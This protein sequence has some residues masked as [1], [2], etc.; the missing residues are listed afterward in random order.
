MKVASKMSFSRSLAWMLLLA[1]P[2]VV[3]SAVDLA[4][5]DPDVMRAMDYAFTD[6]EP[7]LGA[8]NADAA[9]ENVDILKEGYLWTLEYFTEVRPA[10]D[11]AKITKEGLAIVESIERLVSDGDFGAAVVS[12]RKLQ[13]NCKSCHDKYKPKKQ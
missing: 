3:V 5:F 1:V 10:T 7:V 2:V 9:T 8:S 13:A 12:S 11:P 6:L 4:E